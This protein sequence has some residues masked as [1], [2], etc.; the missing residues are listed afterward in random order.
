MLT[1]N[2][3][4]LLI[5]LIIWITIIFFASLDFR[6]KRKLKFHPPISFII[7]CYNDEKTIENTIRSIYASY[8]KDKIDLIVINDHSTDNSPSCLLYTS[9]SPRD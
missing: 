7:P 8:K 5:L 6:R 2:Q 4:S 3:I 9:P 1:V